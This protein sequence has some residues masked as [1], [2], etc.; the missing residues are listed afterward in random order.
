[1]ALGGGEWAAP[2]PRLSDAD[3]ERIAATL[4]RENPG[5]AEVAFS[6]ATLEDAVFDIADNCAADAGADDNAP[7]AVASANAIA[8]RR[9]RVVEV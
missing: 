9:P 8:H 1:L 2:P 6:A 5:A 4:R 3:V 7:A